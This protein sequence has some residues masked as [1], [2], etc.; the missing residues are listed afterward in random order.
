MQTLLSMLA[1]AMGQLKRYGNCESIFL[2]FDIFG[3]FT[4]MFKF[5]HRRYEWLNF[6]AF[7]GCWGALCLSTITAVLVEYGTLIHHD[8][9]IR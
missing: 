5:H 4:R 3:R 1:I 6:M 7:W 8:M 2:L 9:L